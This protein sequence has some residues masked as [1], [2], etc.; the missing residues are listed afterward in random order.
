[1]LIDADGA[2]ATSL[3][4]EMK[5]LYDEGWKIFTKRDFAGLEAQKKKASALALRECGESLKKIDTEMAE[6]KAAFIGKKL[7][8]ASAEKKM[9]E[10]LKAIQAR[11]DQMDIDLLASES[12]K[13]SLRNLE[14]NPIDLDRAVAHWELDRSA[15]VELGKALSGDDSEVMKKLEALGKKLKHKLGGREMFARLR[16]AEFV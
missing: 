9:V 11:R 10:A 5:A 14:L 4:A 13:A 16:K 2:K 12:S 3:K 7:L 1:M 15:K 6:F 8:P